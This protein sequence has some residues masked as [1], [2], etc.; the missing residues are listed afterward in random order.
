MKGAR[1]AN[2]APESF[3]LDR[4]I[5]AKVTRKEFGELLG[6]D[7]S[8]DGG[9]AAGIWTRFYEALEARAVSSPPGLEMIVYAIE[10]SLIVAVREEEPPVHLPCAAR[11]LATHSFETKY[12]L[13]AQDGSFD[14]A[15]AAIEELLSRGNSLLP[16]F[17][18]MLNGESALVDRGRRRWF[19]SLR[20]LKRSMSR[21][22]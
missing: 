10:D 8:C 6:V 4:K 12:I 19:P 14:E 17:Q 15:C 11:Q 3:A 21:E 22:C 5:F 2:A 1:A 16:S 20:R 9:P 13:D 7:I 18:A